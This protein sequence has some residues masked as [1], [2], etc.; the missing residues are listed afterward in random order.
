M[1]SVNYKTPPGIWLQ[2]II[3]YEDPGVILQS[4]LSNS[5]PVGKGSQ[6]GLLGRMDN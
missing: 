1:T 5:P 3:C 6:D 2:I 4:V